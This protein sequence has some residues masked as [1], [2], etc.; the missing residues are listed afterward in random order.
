[1]GKILN[2]FVII[3]HSTLAGILAKINDYLIV[4]NLFGFLLCKQISQIYVSHDNNDA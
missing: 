1:M 2:I 4:D 3:N